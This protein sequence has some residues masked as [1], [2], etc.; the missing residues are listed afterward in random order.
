MLG[1]QSGEFASGFEGSHLVVVERSVIFGRSQ[2]SGGAEAGSGS[3][4]V[5]NRSLYLVVSAS[6]WSSDPGSTFV[7]EL[8]VP[9]ETFC[10]GNGTVPAQCLELSEA[11]AAEDF[12][13][14]T[15]GAA[16]IAVLFFSVFAG[17]CLADSPFDS[18]ASAQIRGAM[19]Q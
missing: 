8:P 14:G 15:A 6:D 2:R 13:R 12:L 5:D 7:S 19:T 4:S 9:P 17:E 16:G 3:R 18:L 1:P 11:F 10:D